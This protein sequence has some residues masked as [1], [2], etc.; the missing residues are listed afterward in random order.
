MTEQ[1]EAVQQLIDRQR[2]GDVLFSYCRHVD[3]FRP[4]KV[5][6]LFTENAV[7]DFGPGLGGPMRGRENLAEFFQGMAAFTATS[8]HLSN[9]VIEFDGADQAHSVSYVYAW[10]SFPG[11]APDAHLYGRYYDRLLRTPG[12]WLIAERTL[13]VAGERGFEPMGFP[14]DQGPV[15]H[16]I[17]RFQAGAIT[18][19]GQL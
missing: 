6:A 1:V 4:Q 15:W 9:V 7:A 19:G 12:G 10:H 8:H 18:G 16:D 14:A 3:E 11:G 2:I 5:A 17:G 13:R